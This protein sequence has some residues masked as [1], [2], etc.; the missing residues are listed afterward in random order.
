MPI[1]NFKCQT[2]GEIELNLKP[3]DIPLKQ[4]PNCN[5]LKIERIF[6]PILSMWKTDGAYSKNN[7]GK[8]GV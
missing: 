6:N 2:C 4:C 8:G 7:H 3:S 1:Y 5:N